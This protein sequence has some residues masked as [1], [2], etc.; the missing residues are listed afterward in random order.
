MLFFGPGDYSHAIGAP[1]D[2]ND[3]R[4]REAR[5]RV[6]DAA[7]RHGK[8]AGTVGSRQNWDELKALGYRFINVGSDVVGL[9]A[10][11]RAIQPG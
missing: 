9:A 4:V 2:L 7:R 3:P 1:G 11:F 8:F 10:H 6:A 5:R